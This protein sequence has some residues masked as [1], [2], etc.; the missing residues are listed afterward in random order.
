MARVN[1][2]VNPLRK[3]LDWKGLGKR[4]KPLV[5]LLCVGLLA[6]GGWWLLRGQSPRSERAAN[7]VQTVSAETQDLQVRVRASGTVTPVQ[8]V[9]VSPKRAGRL[10]QLLVDQGNRVTTGQA[11]AQM[12]SD[13]LAAQLAQAQANLQQA[14]A[15][16]LEAQNG[17]R[18]EDLAG[19]QAQAATAAA[20]VAD[21]E[22][23]LRQAEDDLQRNQKLAADGAIS[24]NSL[25]QFV[26][27][28][29]AA[30]AALAAQQAR[31]A[32][33][34]QN[35]DKL[36]NGTRP[37]QIAAAVAAVAEA[38]AQVQVAQ[39]ELNNTTIRAPFGGIVTQ[40]YAN[41]GAFVTPT[42]S[43]STSA[44]A[45]SSSIVAIASE[46]EIV[47][48]V[49]ETSISQIKRGQP[50]DI[51]ADA[52]PGQTFR[53]SV[54]LISPEAVVEQNVTSFQV[55]VSLRTG[56]AVLRS[57]M[58]VELTFKGGDV[59]GAVVVPTV[60]I[61]NQKGQ[62]GVLVAK[63]SDKPEFRPVTIGMTVGDQVQI[64]DGLKAGESVVVYQPVQKKSDSGPP[65][66][67]R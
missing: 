64:V 5:G 19:G 39:V 23:K 30:R 32:E 53:G 63:G 21:A 41:V 62:T 47:A 66:R 4:R 56:Q 6:T 38:R 33:Q 36:R 43:A 40:K 46:L 37:E 45:T 48:K 35:V 27:Q 54:R 26:T 24:K 18:S 25:N 16:L 58:N 7:A 61:V 29:E 17:T 20:N 9:N 2:P 13:D 28:A 55:R 67:F 12:E 14:E 65:I 34:T 31:L 57:G 3:G 11:I 44:S 59:A 8:A 10:V 52:Y 49:P 22:A 50:V 60:A 1:R 51:R 15:R 42:T